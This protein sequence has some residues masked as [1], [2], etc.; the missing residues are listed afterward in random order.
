M[1]DFSR[2]SCSPHPLFLFLLLATFL[3][4]APVSRLQAGDQTEPDRLT[5]AREALRSGKREIARHLFEQQLRE[6]PQDPESL[7]NLAGLAV[8]GGRLPQA[9]KYYRRLLDVPDEASDARYNIGLIQASQGRLEE[10]IDTLQEV[11]QERPDYPDARLRLGELLERADYIREAEST[12]LE[13]REL[14]PADPAPVIGLAR[15]AEVQ[16]KGG[17]ALDLIQQAERLYPEDPGIVE[18]VGDL[19]GA[20]GKGAEARKAWSRSRDL[21]GQEESAEGAFQRARLA[22]KMGQV[23]LARLDLEACLEKNPLHR[24]ALALARRLLGKR[25]EELSREVKL[26]E[27]LF[28]TERATP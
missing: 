26:G 21:W 19:S 9:L 24:E 5:S 16:G 1:T 23:E 14:V 11:V 3:F 7:Y 17:E 8:D 12:Y 15:L 27:A 4:V 28:A 6:H 10:A 2:F 25:G 20:L 18:R 22:E 13:V